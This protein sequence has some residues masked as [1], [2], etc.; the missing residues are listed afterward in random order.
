MNY[1]YE[2]NR[3]NIM[4]SRY[5]SQ[6]DRLGVTTVVRGLFLQRDFNID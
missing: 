4:L 6:H 3:V 2:V 1:T 5:L